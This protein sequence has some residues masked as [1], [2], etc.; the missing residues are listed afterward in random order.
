M[1]TAPLVSS[2]ANQAFSV[3]FKGVKVSAE[4]K[5]EIL[6]DI[7]KQFNALQKKDETFQKNANDLLRS[8][9]TDKFL[10]VLKSA[11]QRNMARAALRESRKYKGISGDGSARR[12]EGQSRIESGSGSVTQGQRVKY[13]GP[14]EHGG[15]SSTSQI[16]YAAMRAKWGRKGTDERLGNHEFLKKGSGDTI[17]FW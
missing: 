4:A 15:P 11:I 9:D 12:S 10:R 3:A 7:E 6:S 16:D 8:R 14:M 5:K 2:A 13:T 17:F 1:K